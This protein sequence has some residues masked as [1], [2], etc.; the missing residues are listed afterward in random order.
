MEYAN[1]SLIR[2]LLVRIIPEV[3]TIIPVPVRVVVEDPSC[4]VPVILT[5]TGNISPTR[6]GKVS[7]FLDNEVLVLRINSVAH[8]A[9]LRESMRRERAKIIRFIS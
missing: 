9:I 2:C 5:V 1:H 8:T 3:S 7:V 4:M 6:S